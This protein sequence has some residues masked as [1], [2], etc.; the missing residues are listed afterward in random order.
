MCSFADGGPRGFAGIH[1]GGSTAI[2]QNFAISVSNVNLALSYF[3]AI[4]TATKDYLSMDADRLRPY[5]SDFENHL[6][7]L[8]QDKF[9]TFFSR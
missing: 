7:R 9:A 3:N 6:P 4:A 5:Y 2:S 8:V 1:V